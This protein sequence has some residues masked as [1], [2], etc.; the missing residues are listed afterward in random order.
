MSLFEGSFPEILRYAVQ[1]LTFKMEVLEAFIIRQVSSSGGCPLESVL[2]WLWVISGMWPAARVDSL[3]GGQRWRHCVQGPLWE[4]LRL[5][6]DVVHWSLPGDWWQ[7][8][9]RRVHP[10]AWLYQAGP[11]T[12]WEG[13]WLLHVWLHGGHQWWV[14]ANSPWIFIKKGI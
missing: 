1:N 10:E 3:Q 14:I 7:S 6:P 8:Q 13:Q 2:R 4:A 5:H 9:V 11:A 12:H